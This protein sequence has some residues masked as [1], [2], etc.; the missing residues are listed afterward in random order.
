MQETTVNQD[1]FRWIETGL[2][3]LLVAIFYGATTSRVIGSGDTALLVDGI[4]DLTISTHVNNHNLT[5][6]TGWLLSKVVPG[7]LAFIAN[8]TSTVLGALAMTMFWVTLREA[9]DSRW[10]AWATTGAMAVSHSMWWHS[11]TAEV[12]A[13]NA[14]LIACALYALQRYQRL[15]DRKSVLGLFFVSGLAFFNHVQ[16]GV[17]GVAATWLMCAHFLIERPREERTVANGVRWFLTCSAVFLA[18]F[19][20]YLLTFVNDAR[21]VKSVAKALKSATGGDFQSLMFK[22]TFWNG[23][24]EASYLTWM[25]FPTAFLVLVLLGTGL[26]Y[27]RWGL[28]RSLPGLAAMFAVNTHFFMHFDTWDRFAFLLPSFLCLAFAGAFGIDA[29]LG[30]ATASNRRSYKALAIAVVV[31]SV[32]V[33]PWFYANLSRWGS[34]EASV[35]YGRYSNRYSWHLYDHASYVTNPDKHAYREFDTFGR[36]LFEKLPPGSVFFDDDSRAYYQLKYFQRFEKLRPDVDVRMVNSWGFSNW[37]D[38]PD[39]LAQWLER[40]YQRN[41]PLFVATLGTPFDGFLTTARKVRDF[42]FVPFHLDDKRWVY[43]LVTAGESGADAV[44]AKPDSVTALGVDVGTGFNAGA[45]ELKARFSTDDTVMARFRSRPNEVP[46]SIVF[47]WKDAQ[48]SL[49]HR[50]SPYLVAIG[51]T[52]VWSGL[53]KPAPQTKGEWTVDVRVENEIVGSSRFQV[54]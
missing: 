39:G 50:S 35:W 40:A 27:R 16:L 12:Y 5:V 4:A 2:L 48:G 20:P 14:L 23:L 21:K 33:P 34:D 36:D 38:T 18:G 13:A 51:N 1:R 42:R 22:G 41:D 43:R 29:L 46:Y 47:E 8:L 26:A 6:L 19:L 32:L 30:L 28:R 24:R 37:G 25:Q 7:S 15:G 10:T 31:S 17:I 45:G 49:V 54:E 44:V 52:S 53:E 3:A 11:T 9:F